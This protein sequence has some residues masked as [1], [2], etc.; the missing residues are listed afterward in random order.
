MKQLKTQLLGIFTFIIIFNSSSLLA[1]ANSTADKQRAM[2]AVI[3]KM[4][5][6][7]IALGRLKNDYFHPIIANKRS[8]PTKNPFANLP[9]GAKAALSKAGINVAAISRYKAI[10]F[11]GEYLGSQSRRII[12]TAPDTV[13]VIGRGTRTHNQIFSRGPVVMLGDS[14]DTGR[15]IS[16]NLVWYGNRAKLA[17][18]PSTIA[19]PSVNGNNA[20]A[21]VTIGPQIELNRIKAARQY[22]CQNYAKFGVQ[23]HAKNKQLGCG[24]NSIRWNNNYQGQFNWCMT[25]LEPVSN[26]E[27]NFRKDSLEKCQAQKGGTNNPKNRPAIPAA[28]NDPSKQYQAVKQ[29][30][31]SFRYEKKLTS[32][33]QNGMIRYDYNRDKRHD[34]VF[35]EVK[36]ESARIA[37][38]LSRNNSYQR[39]VTDVKF[40]A[41]GDGL[42]SSNYELSQ[43]GDLLNLGIQYFEHNGGSSSRNLSYRYMTATRKF[44]IIKNKADSYGV[45]M[46]GYTYPM[47]LPQ[48][49]KLF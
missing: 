19:L 45:E 41:S 23:Q 14:G 8:A 47:S 42:F 20:Q 22:R 2:A 34:Y 7:H 6:Q 40:S 12:N 1:S 4:I 27:Y 46:D 48:I 25:V 39:H 3:E 26:T 28:C 10:Y 36:G 49:F 5:R 21:V 13:L 17:Q 35:L 31:H 24:F 37:V 9:A 18:T 29:I 44:K 15:I 43:S 32:P 11:K 16:S 38:C 30:N 33:V